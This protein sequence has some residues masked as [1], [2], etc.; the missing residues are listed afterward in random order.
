VPDTASTYEQGGGASSLVDDPIRLWIEP[1]G[2]LLVTAMESAADLDVITVLQDADADGV[3]EI[4]RSS[5][6]FE[7]FYPGPQLRETP[8]SGAQ[9]VAVAGLRG[10]TLQ[11]WK[12][13]SNGVKT[14]ADPLV[15]M[16]GEV[17]LAVDSP[18]GDCTTQLSVVDGDYLRV[19]DVTHARAG[20]AR[21]V[22]LAHPIVSTVSPR[23]IGAAAGGTIE[24]TGT[25]FSSNTEAELIGPKLGEPLA[26]TVV[27]GSITPTSIQFVVPTLD[28]L[29]QGI[30]KVRVFDQNSPAHESVVEMIVTE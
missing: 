5:T 6:L 23:E 17:T 22:M 25:G 12:T 7:E 13:D 2:V 30:V 21:E 20:V 3:A 11:V 16:V 10:A 15:A 8:L 26:I 9:L 1:N 19:F 24:L 28:A 27:A 14:S 29:W 18:T 4:K